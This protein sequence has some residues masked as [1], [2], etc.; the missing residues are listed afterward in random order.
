MNTR[1]SVYTLK[2]RKVSGVLPFTLPRRTD[3][4]ISWT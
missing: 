2:R 3:I 1:R 4:T